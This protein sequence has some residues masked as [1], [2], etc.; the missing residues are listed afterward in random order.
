MRT[1]LEGFLSFLSPCML[2]LL[3]VY[4]A[5]FAA[6]EAGRVKTAVR[7]AAFMLGFTAVFVLMGV[8]AGSAGSALAAHRRTV[9]IVCGVLVMVLALGFF[10][11]FRLPSFGS[12]R[13]VRVQGVFSAFF[14]GVVF[15]LCLS[16][17]VGAFLAAALLEAASEG[18]ALSGGLKLAAYSAG[19]GV[20]M[21][22]SALLVDRLKGALSFLRGHMRALNILCGAVLLWFG[23]S[24]ALPGCSSSADAEGPAAAQSGEVRPADGGKTGAEVSSG[25]KKAVSVVGKER[26]AR[27][28]LSA[29]GDVLV[30]FWAPWCGPC[31]K[32]N[33]VIDEIAAAGKVKVVKINIDENRGLAS[34]YGIRALPSFKLFRAGRVVREVVGGLPRAALEKALGIGSAE[35][36]R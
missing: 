5:Y 18:G 1:F 9:E 34:E 28:V 15:S 32:M 29:E 12:G 2:P 21:I 10:G 14:F 11:L 16:P 23:S 30:D 22:V 20:P 8:L 27:E 17:C 35:A 25:V 13:A 19:L 7:A 26:F 4:L 36:E 24:M 33:P 31:M 6:G 3:P